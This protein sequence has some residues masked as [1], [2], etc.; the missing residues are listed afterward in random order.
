MRPT[1]LVVDD[2]PALRELMARSLVVE[3]FDVVTAADA[4]D[5]WALIDR[6]GESFGLIIVDAFMPG[7]SGTA[8]VH[9]TREHYPRQRFLLVTGRVDRDPAIGLPANVPVLLKPFT[10]CDIVQAARSAILLP[11]GT[12]AI[13]P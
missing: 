5:A 13:E 8:L 4:R 6:P 10:P 1:V 7:G 12:A 3:G 11:V 2:E 9:R